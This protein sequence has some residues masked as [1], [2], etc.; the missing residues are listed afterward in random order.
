MMS[1]DLNRKVDLLK[2]KL[3]Q[4]VY[5]ESISCNHLIMVIKDLISYSYYL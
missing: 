1:N 3:L 5:L 2:I 4:N